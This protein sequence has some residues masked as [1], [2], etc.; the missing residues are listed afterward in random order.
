MGSLAEFDIFKIRQINNPWQ[1]YFYLGA[2][3]SAPK[4][5]SV[6]RLCLLHLFKLYNPD[7]FINPKN[8]EIRIKFHPNLA[9]SFF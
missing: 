7:P 9:N 3:L 5:K 6:F 4:D 2:F 8:I 1:L